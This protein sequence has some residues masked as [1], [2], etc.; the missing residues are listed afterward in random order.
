MNARTGAPKLSASCTYYHVPGDK[1][2][3]TGVVVGDEIEGNSIWYRDSG[4]NYFWSGGF[5]EKEFVI[6]SAAFKQMDFNGQISAGL[7]IIKLMLS[8]FQENIAD[9]RGASVSLKRKSNTRLNYHCI[10][11]Y[12]KKKSDSFAY[13]IPPYVD[14]LG[15]RVETDV[16]VSGLPTPSFIGQL[17]NREGL[18]DLGSAGFIYRTTV[19]DYLLTNFHVVCPDYLTTAVP[20][21]SIPKNVQL[22]ADTNV[23][24][25]GDIVGQL[26]CANLNN[27][28]D[29]AIIELSDQGGFD[30]TLPNAVV[31]PIGSPSNSNDIVSEIIIDKNNYIDKFVYMYGARSQTTSSGRITG[32][33]PVPIRYFNDGSTLNMQGIIITERI[34]IK[35]DSGSIVYDGANK[36]VGILIGDNNETNGAD[37]TASYIIPYSVVFQTLNN[38]SL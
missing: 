28:A 36:I 6:D 38:Y 1:L 20:D 22:P 8:V 31:L 29:L 25:S 24:M 11:L 27:S 19:A 13:Q 14:M 32:W 3:V 18:T 26:T 16:I 35:G 37:G 15:L 33:G 12:V 4:Q 9:F 30:N 2:E 7:S 23:C 21:I 34:S 10:A 17:I 5:D